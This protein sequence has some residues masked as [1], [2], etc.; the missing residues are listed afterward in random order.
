MALLET[1]RARLDQ[2]KPVR[3]MGL[4]IEQQRLLKPLCLLTAKPAIYVANV[5]EKGLRII[6]YLREWRNMPPG[7]GAC[8]SRF[9]RHWKRKLLRCRMRTRRFFLLT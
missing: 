8:R 5:D 1:V 6:R 4:D 3:G 9:A 2:G 7:R